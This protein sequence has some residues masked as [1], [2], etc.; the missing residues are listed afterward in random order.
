MVSTESVDESFHRAVEVVW[1]MT[2]KA[3]T[4]TGVLR[5]RAW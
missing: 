3:E 1:V 5:W 2:R 4:V